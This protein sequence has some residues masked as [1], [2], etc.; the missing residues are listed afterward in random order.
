MALSSLPSV[1]A[2]VVSKIPKPR[3]FFSS[4]SREAAV[5]AAAGVKLSQTDVLRESFI[6]ESICDALERAKELNLTQFSP[7]INDLTSVELNPLKPIAAPIFTKPSPKTY[8]TQRIFV[9]PHPLLTHARH[10]ST[11][12]YGRQAR[13]QD[14]ARLQKQAD[15][16]PRDETAQYKY[17]EALVAN[18]PTKVISRVESQEYNCNNARCLEIYKRAIEERSSGNPNRQSKFGR[19][20]DQTSASAEML[21]FVRL[22]IM[23]GVTYFVWTK[24]SILNPSGKVEF[25]GEIPSETFDDVAGIDSAVDEMKQLVA[26]LADT[27]KYSEMGCKIPRGYLLTGPP[28]VGKTLLAKALAGEANVPFFHATGSDFDEMFVGVGAS[29]MRKLFKAAKESSPSIIFIDEID[30]FGGKRG[31]QHN[32]VYKATLNTLL[33]EM[34]GFEGNSGVIVIAATNMVDKLDSALVRTGRFDHKI[35]IRPP[36]KDGRHDILKVHTFNKNLSPEVNLEDIAKA[37]PGMTGSDL[38]TIINTAT[39]RA[40]TQGKA[41][42]DQ[43]DLEFGRANTV[44]GGVDKSVTPSLAEKT[45]TAYHEGGHAAMILIQKTAKTAI[46]IATI[47]ARGQSLGH[48][49]PVPKEDMYS[50]SIEDIIAMIDVC[51]GGRIAEELYSGEPGKVTTGCSSDMSRATQLAEEL[52]GRNG[53]SSKL[54]YARFDETKFQCNET[55]KIIQDEIK[56]LLDE[57]YEHVTK[58]LKKHKS[59]WVRL[60]K[61]L[62]EYETL[63]GDECK[64]VWDGYT[65][66]RG[67]DDGIP[68]S[69]AR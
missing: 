10:Y 40:V 25:S 50:Q 33:S 13:T 55:H 5:T 44:M 16:M 11:A 68:S 22:V 43:D 66:S 26:L 34:D 18:D 39:L 69:A 46:Y 53:Y 20:S 1:L 30:S 59:N 3:S 56:E 6:F 8:S 17:L 24:A 54:G 27:T 58:E 7:A 42:V 47:Q 2:E 35:A 49:F 62:L 51:L 60:S 41:A 45:N 64:L 15:R 65:L 29:R 19:F 52:I 9:H 48:V 38:A 4:S 23:A 12:G 31:D 14:I 28:G 36:N 21:K 37:T 57:R 61:T 67:P 32:G 63:T